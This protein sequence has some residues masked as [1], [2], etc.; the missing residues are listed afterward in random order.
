MGRRPH[1][2]FHSRT[3]LSNNKLYSCGGLK[4]REWMW[5]LVSVDYS[6]RCVRLE[7]MKIQRGSASL[8]GL[9]HLLIAIG[10]MNKQDFR[11]EC[12]LYSVKTNKWGVLPQLN[13]AR[14]QPGS[15][16][17]QSMRAFCFSGDKNFGSDLAWDLKS[18]EWKRVEDTSSWK[19]DRSL[20][21]SSNYLFP[22]KHTFLRR[23]NRISSG[24]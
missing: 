11:K 9:P 10:G 17:L 15:I 20:F 2:D 8:S 24:L 14:Y 23:R 7:P 5:D 12:E 22:K 21:Q 3:S 19:Q 4:I 18:R 1:R 16:L 13:A 6:G